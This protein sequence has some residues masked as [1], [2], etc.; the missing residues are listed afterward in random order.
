MT[1]LQHD[2][3]AALDFYGTLFGWEMESGP[4]AVPRRT[5]P[6]RSRGREVAAIG[7][8]PVSDAH[9]LRGATE[10]STDD[11]EATV[12]RVRAAGGEVLQEAGPLRPGRGGWWCS[13]APG[14][15]SVRE[16]GT[17][18]GAQ[19][20]ERAER[21]VDDASRP[22]TPNVRRGSTATSSAGRRRRVS[23]WPR[24]SGC[25]GYVGGEEAQPV[26][27]DVVAVM[28]PATADAPPGAARTSGS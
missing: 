6:G 2:V 16:A 26:P 1:N 14:R 3:P 18:Q 7:T 4:R 17:R 13:P 23:A 15:P 28:V 11:L 21:L 27:R 22:T 8:M 19:V 24:C 12:G 25:P 5:P 10:V 20:N 9:P